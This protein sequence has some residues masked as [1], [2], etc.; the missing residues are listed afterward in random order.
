MNKFYF[1]LGAEAEGLGGEC[2]E[3]KTPYLFFSIKKRCS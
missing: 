3:A 2:H 1:C